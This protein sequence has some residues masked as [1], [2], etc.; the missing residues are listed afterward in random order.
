MKIVKL[1]WVLIII[2]VRSLFTFSRRKKYI[3]HMAPSFSQKPPHQFRKAT[4]IK[5]K[6]Q[7]IINFVSV[8]LGILNI[9]IP[10]AA[11]YH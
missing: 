6:L 10:L 2:L 7:R 11:K 1:P 3:F 4:G 8:P 9:L 5:G